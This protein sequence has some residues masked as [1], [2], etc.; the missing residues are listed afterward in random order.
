MIN[1]KDILSAIESGDLDQHRELINQALNARSKARAQ[2]VSGT[3]KE[4]QHVRITGITPKWLNGKTGKIV[5]R[6]PRGVNR[7]NVMLDEKPMAPDTQ[8]QAGIPAA[9]IEI[10]S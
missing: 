7:F 5:G 2:E 10:I 6:Y 9:C 3:L 4:G 8:Q 1:I